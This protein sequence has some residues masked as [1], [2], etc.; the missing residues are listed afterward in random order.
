MSLIL[1]NWAQVGN[2]TAATN[3]LII[4]IDATPIMLHSLQFIENGNW[5]GFYIVFGPLVYI[6]FLLICIGVK[7]LLLNKFVIYTIRL[8]FS[9][10]HLISK[11]QTGIKMN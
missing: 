1:N 10:F 4:M 6:A 3:N 9:N 2:N 7:N 5:F 8:K 11:L